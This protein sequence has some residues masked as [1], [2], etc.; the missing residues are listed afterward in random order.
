MSVRLP[1]MVA[2]DLRHCLKMLFRWICSH[3]G[4]VIPWKADGEFK[5]SSVADFGQSGA[6]FHPA[7]ANAPAHFDVSSALE[8]T[9]INGNERG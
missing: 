8:A 9:I 5:F 7:V 2:G 6:F 1:E 3:Y 4:A